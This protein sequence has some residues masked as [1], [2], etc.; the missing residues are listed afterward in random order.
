MTK[1]RRRKR[2][3]EYMCWIKR[4]PCIVCGTCR[5]VEAAHCGDHAGFRKGSDNETLP[6]C[7]I[8]HRWEG[9][10]FSLHRLTDNQF[11]TYWNL[12]RGKLIAEFQEKF[13]IRHCTAETV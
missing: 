5:R 6:L 1:Y 13:K 9:G 12:N 7:V 8:H 10:Q 4:Q 2:D 11:W 3:L